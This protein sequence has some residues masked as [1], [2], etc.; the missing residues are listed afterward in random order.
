MSIAAELIA[1]LEEEAAHTRTMLALVP[2]GKLAWKPHEKSMSVG[3]LASHLAEIPS[4]TPG[5]ADPVFDL[6]A[7][8]YKP[9]LGGSRAEIV[10]AFEKHHREAVEW[11]R[12]K[13]D[14]FLSATWTMKQGAAVLMATP[15]HR[16]LRGIV[17]H[18]PI[19]HRAQLGVCFRLLG[20]ALPPLY[21]P[22]ADTQSAAP[23]TA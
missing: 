10:A 12:G 13:D 15:R 16:A 14:R 8:D 11:I 21:G 5:F 4:W 23:A 18:H 6:A 2:D 3:Q 7:M 17:L 1:D 22:T 19:H 20:I 9:W